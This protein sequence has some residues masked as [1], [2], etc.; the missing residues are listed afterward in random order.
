MFYAFQWGTGTPNSFHLKLVPLWVHLW[1]VP[2]NLRSLEGLGWVAGELGNPKETDEYT[3]NLVSLVLS[4][5]KVEMDLT[6]PLPRT[7]KLLRH[8]GQVVIVEVDYPWVPPTCSNCSELGHIR[9]N[10]LLPLND[11]PPH[12]GSVHLLNSLAK[13]LVFEPS[14]APTISHPE[15][16]L[17]S[18][19]L[20]SD[21]QTVLNSPLEDSEFFFG[22]FGSDQ[23]CTDELTMLPPSRQTIII[24]PSIVRPDS[25]DT[26]N[27]KTSPQTI[28]APA[29]CRIL[30]KTSQ[31]VTCEISIGTSFR[32]V[33]T[34]I[35]A[36]NTAAERSDLWVDLLNTH[37]ALSLDSRPWLIVGDFNQIL[38]PA[39]HSS[40]EVVVMDSNMCQFRDTLF[41]TR[42]IF[43]VEWVVHHQQSVASFLPPEFSDYSPFLI[44]L[45]F[46]LPRE[47]TRPF[48]FFNYLTKHHEFTE[49]IEDA[50]LQVGD[51]SIDLSSFDWKLKKFKWDLKQ[52]DKSNFSNIQQRVDAAL[53]SLQYAQTLYLNVTT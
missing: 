50:W 1:D 53:V 31:D 48:K 34:A 22:F 18:E 12:S 38:N 33:F 4:H 52:L 51:I 29:N 23:I 45:S 13:P 2:L 3:I 37:Q 47:G 5:V 25:R 32:I 30:H 19:N 46:Q 10:C 8:N 42:Q 43:G 28:K 17:D 21:H 24:G 15:I 39:E 6:K 9:R 20:H 7:I 41:Q 16:G 14:F 27:S 11:T 44:D 49:K 40:T 35:Y 36:F 26:H